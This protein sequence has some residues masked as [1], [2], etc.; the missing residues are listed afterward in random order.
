M[1]AD[2]LTLEVGMLVQIK[3]HGEVHGTFPIERVTKTMAIVGGA[4]NYRLRRNYSHIMAS[5]DIFLSL[6][7]P[8]MW[9]PTFILKQQASNKQ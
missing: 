6:A 5:G 7:R 9:A 8:R 1:N 2:D 4:Y 3:K